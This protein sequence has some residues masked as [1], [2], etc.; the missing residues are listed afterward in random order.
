MLHLSDLDTALATMLQLAQ[1]SVL[2]DEVQDSVS[3]SVI[4]SALSH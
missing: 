3:V 2:Q 1:H 4:T